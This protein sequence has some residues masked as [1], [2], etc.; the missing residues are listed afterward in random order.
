MSVKK[1]TQ[2]GIALFVYSIYLFNQESQIVRLKMQASPDQDR[3]SNKFTANTKELLKNN[4]M[5]S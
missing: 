3:T 2:L 4:K 1:V 5:H